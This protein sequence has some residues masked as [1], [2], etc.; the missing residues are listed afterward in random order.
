MR[1]LK[2]HRTRKFLYL[3]NCVTDK[4]FNVDIIYNIILYYD[5]LLYCLLFHTIQVT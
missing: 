1:F 4:E 5:T 3:P 2:I